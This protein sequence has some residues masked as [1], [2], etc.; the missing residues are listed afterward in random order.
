M[1]SREL[2]PD[3]E[4]YWEPTDG[5]RGQEFVTVRPP[6]SY[7]QAFGDKP[8]QLGVVEFRILTFL[9]GWPYHA[10]TRRQIADCLAANALEVDETAIDDHVTNLRDQLGVLGDFVQT[11][12]HVGYRYK[13]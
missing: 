11:V 3:D 2:I 8:I 12:P 13:A 4:H 10:Y 6:T 5:D 1:S 7:R 9:A